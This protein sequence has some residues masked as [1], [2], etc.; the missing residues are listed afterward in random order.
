VKVGDGYCE[1]IRCIAI[2]E[3]HAAPAGTQT[4]YTLDARFF[5][6]ANTVKVSFRN[7]TFQLVDEQGRRFEESSSSN[8]FRPYDLY[9]EPQQSIK[10]A[11]TFTVPSDAHQLF[12][13]YT[14]RTVPD[15]TGASIG[16][17][18]PPPTWAIAPVGFW[19]YFASLG[20]DAS[21]FHKPTLLQVL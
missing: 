19:F 10:E 9:L 2:E 18:K 6:D 8:S 17:K 14:T 12:L 11:L 15:G 1:D 13:T 21:P 20:N 16:G 4:Q 7:A 3:V 5:S